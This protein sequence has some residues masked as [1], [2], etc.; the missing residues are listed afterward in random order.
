M[1]LRPVRFALQLCMGSVARNVSPIG[2]SSRDSKDR[3]SS[4]NVRSTACG[5]KSSVCRKASTRSKCS[6]NDLRDERKRYSRFDQFYSVDFVRCRL[7]QVDWSINQQKIPER[8]DDL[9]EMDLD[10]KS[11]VR[12]A[13]SQQANTTRP[14]KLHKCRSRRQRGARSSVGMICII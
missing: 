7:D 4:G 14:R 2:S 12:D 1:L 9:E 5:S 10:A 8:V 13:H 11:K 3:S 6:N